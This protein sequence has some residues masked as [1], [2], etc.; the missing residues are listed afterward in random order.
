MQSGGPGWNDPP[1]LTY[2]V[3]SETTSRRHVL[4]KR[5]SYL[6]HPPSELKPET[7]LNPNL[8]PP[9]LN[10]NLPPPVIDSNSSP[11]PCDETNDENTISKKVESMDAVDWIAGLRD[12]ADKSL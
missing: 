1:N 8:P 3:H 12:L 2:K 11:A 10:P 4:N 9:R 6:D 7:A 5:V